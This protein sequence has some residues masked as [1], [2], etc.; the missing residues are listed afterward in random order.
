MGLEIRHNKAKSFENEAFRRIAKMLTRYFEE[1]KYEGIL[2]GNPI[3][4]DYPTFCPDILLFYNNGAIII[5]LKDGKGL[6]SIPEEKD[7]FRKKPW[8]LDGREVKAGAIQN[9]N[10]FNQLDYIHKKYFSC[11]KSQTLKYPSAISQLTPPNKETPDFFYYSTLVLFSGKIENVNTI[12]IPYPYNRYF[13]VSDETSLLNSLEDISNNGKF[14][15]EVATAVKSIFKA[16]PYEIEAN[17]IIENYESNTSINY[18]EAQ[19]ECLSKIKSFLKNK[20]EKIL[21]LKG[22]EKAGKTALITEIKN[23]AGDLNINQIETWAVTKRIASK[24]NRQHPEL[25]FTSIYSAIYGGKS[26]IVLEE[27]SFINNEE[28][29]DQL[30]EVETVPLRKPENQLEKNSLIIVD[31]AQLL[32]S[33]QFSSETMIFGSGKL[34]N[35]VLKFIDLSNSDRKLILIG[36]PN[37][38]SY[39]GDDT[40]SLMLGHL[41][42]LTGLDPKAIELLS[43]KD[44]KNQIDA[45]IDW[46]ADCIRHETYNSFNI[47]YGNDVR[48]LRDKQEWETLIREHYSNAN[49]L[50]I[51]TFKNESAYDANIYVR[52]SILGLPEN[53]S[54]GDLLIMDNNIRILSD[55]PFEAP[56][57][58]NNGVVVEVLEVYNENSLDPI[59]IPNLKKSISLKTREVLVKEKDKEKPSKILLLE[60]YRLSKSASLSH[61]ESIALKILLSKLVNNAPKASEFE[62]S[63]VYKQMISNEIYLTLLKDLSELEAAVARDE[64]KNTLLKKKLAEK[65]RIE[66]KF[67]KHFLYEI[68]IELSRSHPLFQLAYVRYSYAMTVHKSLGENF[69]AVLLDANMGENKGMNRTYYQWFYT[70]VSR[71]QSILYIL[72]QKTFTPTSGVQLGE[73]TNSII[74]E[75]EIAPTPKESFRLQNASDDFHKQNSDLKADV[76]NMAFTLQEWLNKNGMSAIVDATRKANYLIKV[77]TND[78]ST[79]IVFNFN[80]D[81]IPSKPRIERG[82]NELKLKF[83]KWLDE[84]S[85]SI[86][87]GSNWRSS[88]YSTWQKQLA[89]KGIEWKHIETYNYQ[90]R[91][92][93]KRDKDFLI[94]DLWW[95][96]SKFITKINPFRANNESIWK[97]LKS[98]LSNN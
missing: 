82:S 81:G 3:I 5:D 90:E 17:I 33:S 26:E 78:E 79:T 29:I 31:E 62:R 74:H 56:K 9:I 85:E 95:D 58:L 53:L 36:D 80:G 30:T 96:G 7:Q 69:P 11:L 55:D 67:K 46:L 54:K 72:N 71:A 37:Q 44:S 75:N 34:L 2:I 39:G 86:E 61:E 42:H 93:L 89:I 35:D 51:L 23:I 4:E 47:I 40:S 98:M 1:K 21:V 45:N 20:D 16:D 92:W 77:K 25:N 64:K 97:D 49:P 48:I 38:L 87:N 84:I 52:R 41:K 28:E 18:S 43:K 91:I 68:Q 8:T 73:F 57:F 65:K 19:N 14:N 6:L 83:L 27:D 76:R 60:N 22:K 50:T 13:F 24:L 66:R 10:P 94:F 88:I 59:Y 70:A 32:N 15:K 63:D 12:S